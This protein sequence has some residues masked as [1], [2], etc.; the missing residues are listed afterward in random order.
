MVDERR[1][2][3]LAL[4]GGGY[5]ASLFHLGSLW[6]L[7]ELGWLP[8]LD[9]ITSVSGGTITAA[10]L[11]LNWDKLEFNQNGISTT[12]QP[13]VVEPLR[14][15]FSESLDVRTGLFGALN[16]FSSGAEQ[17]VKAYDKRLFHGRTLQ[18]L[19]DPNISGHP[20]FTLYATNLQTGVSVRLARDYMADY[21][22]GKINYPKVSLARATAASS[23][24]PPF[25]CPVKLKTEL[26][27]WTSFETADLSDCKSLKRNMLLGDG[28]IYDNMGLQRL[29]NRRQTILVS[30]AGAPF[31]IKASIGFDYLRRALRVLDIMSEQTR[32]LRRV[33][34]VEEYK[35]KHREGTYWGI[36]TKI[37]DYATDDIT[38]LLQDSRQTAAL[39][40]MRTRLNAFNSG[41]QEALINWGYALADAAMR[42]Y[43]QS[44][45]EPGRLP[46]PH[47]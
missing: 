1:G 4:S 9:D 45:A 8:T 35:K 19:P 16:P 2:R 15:F 42:R 36:A 32:A 14:D 11:A 10:W 24:F 38:P 23:G 22:L 39:A 18:D 33:S 43:V 13:L 6:R 34:L 26:A 31:G 25:F 17:L 30:D 29:I 46:Y 37:R 47:P 40:N 28:G 12:F 44:G 7:N 41:E 21:R 3:G 20:R 27:D 5:R